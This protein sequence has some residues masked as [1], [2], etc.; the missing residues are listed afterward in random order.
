MAPTYINTPL[1]AFVFDKP[2]MYEAW[3]GRTP[4]GRMGEVSEIASVVLFLAGDGCEPD[5]RQRRGGRRRL[6]L[7]VRR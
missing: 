3:I 1:N 6:Y 5:D 4:M 2:E 7:L